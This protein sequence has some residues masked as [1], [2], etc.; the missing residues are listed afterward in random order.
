MY[1]GQSSP[2]QKNHSPRSDGKTNFCKLMDGP[3]VLSIMLVFP[4]RPCC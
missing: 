3:L 2:V 1:L 4:S